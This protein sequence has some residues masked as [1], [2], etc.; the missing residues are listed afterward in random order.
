MLELLA[1]CC[2]FSSN[3]FVMPVWLSRLRVHYFLPAL[4]REQVLSVGHISSFH[5]IDDGVT[6]PSLLRF[7]NYYLKFR[8]ESIYSVVKDLSPVKLP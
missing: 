3:L 8:R 4:P 2:S 1:G 5:D 6:P 7:L